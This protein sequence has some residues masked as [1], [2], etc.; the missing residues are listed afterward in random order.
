MK[1]EQCHG[2]S[3]WQ[4]PRSSHL[5]VLAD[6]WRLFGMLVALATGYPAW[7]DDTPGQK[8]AVPMSAQ[9]RAE[10][11]H[12]YADKYHYYPDE[13]RL[14]RCE[15]RHGRRQFC[16][17]DTRFGV[18]LERQ[19]GRPNCVGNWGYDQRGIWVRNGCAAVF[20][21]NNDWNSARGWSGNLIR[22][23]SEGYRER[24]CPARLGGRDVMLVR[25]LSH[26][27][28]DGNW[29]YDRNGI[30]VNNGCRAEFAIDDRYYQHGNTL[31]CS[32]ERHRFKRCPADT[33]WG[34]KF[35]RQL[36]RSSCRGNWGYDQYG[37][38]V[39]NGCRAQFL[40]ETPPVGQS[41]S[42]P[43]RIQCSSRKGRYK[44][45]RTDTGDGVELVKQHSRAS[46]QGNWGY[47][48]QGIWVDNGCRATFRI[49]RRHGYSG[50]S[51]GQPGYGNH[52]HS[53]PYGKPSGRPGYGQQPLPH[54]ED[55]RCESINGHYRVCPVRRPFAT[56]RLLRR[57]S[58]ASC[59]GKWGQV[60]DGIW[61]DKGC[62]ATFRVERR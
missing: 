58:R 14:V 37:I 16:P 33:R 24:Y 49:I 53:G 26:S 8:A 61:V 13:S 5:S 45:C 59:A 19:L 29:G 46:C 40:T 28:C 31:V 4:A 62:R 55:V 35:V 42:Y 20:S 48:E 17:A 2:Y 57:H 44:L 22:C 11:D 36:S 60:A 39:D 51:Y 43:D 6:R 30:W 54:R 34:V 12:T 32:S 41:P 56:V 25:Q 47:N 23:E 21:I 18:N 50:S 15:S 1:K 7:A 9:A 27:T 38:W 52:P 3:L 10:L